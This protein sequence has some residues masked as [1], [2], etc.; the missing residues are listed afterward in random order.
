MGSGGHSRSANDTVPQ[1]RFVLASANPHKVAEIRAIIGA[2]LPGVRLDP[3][4]PGLADV[5]EDAETLVGNARLKASAVM[6][7]TIS[8]AIADDTGLF[9]DALGGAPGVRT[10][11]FAGDGATDAQNRA[12]L[13]ADIRACRRRLNFAHSVQA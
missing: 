11:R 4:P 5:S 13:L 9:V 8:P 1:P 12:K 10:A 3:R 7:A 2:S 6:R